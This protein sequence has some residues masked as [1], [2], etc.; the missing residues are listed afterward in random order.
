[1]LQKINETADFLMQQF[2]REAKIAIVLGTGLNN[3]G[4]DIEIEK[5][6]DYKDIVNFPV[7]TVKGH[8]GKLLYGTLSGVKVIAMQGRFHYYEGYNMKEITFPVRVFKAM[9]IETLILSNASGGMNPLYKVGEMVIITD[10][11]NLF[12]ENPLRGKNY[13]ELGDRFPDMS[14][15][16]TRVLIEKAE[17]IAKHYHIPY[18]KG[19]YVGTAGPTF[20]TPSEYK[21]FR[22]LGG[23]CVGMS[24]VPEA[25]V[26]RHAGMQCIAFSVI[27]DLGIIGVVEKVSHEEVLNAAKIAEPKIRQV[28]KE[29]V[30]EI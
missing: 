12:P 17:N 13:D 11:I 25:I 14:E 7:S 6:I 29:L 21:M 20:E 9:G 2:G 28:V 5:A 19:V 27:T 30:K 24:T 16:Y 23:D 15:A 8:E 18:Q 10:H 22:L 3:L 4:A 26:A 1:M